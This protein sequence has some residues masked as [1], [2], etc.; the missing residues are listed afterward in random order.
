MIVR[1]Q[2][3]PVKVGAVVINERGVYSIKDKKR[4]PT[5]LGPKF[6]VFLQKFD[7]LRAKIDVFGY[8]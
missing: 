7:V 5:F 3:L 1:L 8:I 4:K 6:D 2:P